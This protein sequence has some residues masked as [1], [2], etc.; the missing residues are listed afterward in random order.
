MSADE[1]DEIRM[2]VLCVDD[3]PVLLR[4]LEQNARLAVPD[5]DIFCFT[6]AKDALSHAEKHG[7]DVLFTEIDL[8]HCGGI[9]LAASIRARFPQA[10]II[11]VTVC[12]EKEYAEEMQRLRPSGYLTKP[13]T[14]Q[15]IVD[16]LRNLCNPAVHE[17]HCDCMIQM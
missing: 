9:W 4:G 10:S 14:Q 6:R 12:S 5:A 17:M 11:F 13:V 16:K 1:G 15:Q 8:Y 2:K 7:C 3:H